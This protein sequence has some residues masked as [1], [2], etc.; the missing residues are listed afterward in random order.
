MK[1]L[2]SHERQ[3]VGRIKALL[4]A[5]R[6]SA[7]K[8]ILDQVDKELFKGVT[9]NSH[10][11]NRLSKFQQDSE[12]LD[13]ILSLDLEGMKQKDV[14]ELCITKFGGERSPKRNALSLKWSW[15]KAKKLEAK[16]G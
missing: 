8:A 2:N 10:T 13:F 7:G 3:T 15:L 16:Y 4:M 6:K 11:K 9:A 12:V 14:I 1:M 5:H